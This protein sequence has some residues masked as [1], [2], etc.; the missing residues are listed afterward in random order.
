MIVTAAC[1]SISHPLNGRTQNIRLDLAS[2]KDEN[3]GNG[4]SLKMGGLMTTMLT[5][6]D[7]GAANELFTI[8]ERDLVISIGDQATCQV[9]D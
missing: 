2:K 7:T 4:K 1:V 3:F 5:G 8:M 9:F 6:V